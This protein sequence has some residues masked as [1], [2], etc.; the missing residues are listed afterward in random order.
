MAQLNNIILEE[1]NRCKSMS[2]CDA[3]SYLAEQISLFLN[4]DNNI[5]CSILAENIIRN[6]G[7]LNEKELNENPLA[8]LGARLFGK[9]LKNVGTRVAANA[10]TKAFRQVGQN[11][12]KKGGKLIA[13][14][15]K[16]LSHV[17]YVKALQKAGLPQKMTNKMSNK[18]AAQANKYYAQAIT[19]VEKKLAG[20]KVTQNEFDKMVANRYKQIVKNEV[21]ANPNNPIAKEIAQ[22]SGRNA[23]NAANKAA[24]DTEKGASG[25]GGGKS[26][27]PK[28]DTNG[29]KGWWAK[30]KT[31]LKW[32]LSLAALTAAGYTLYSAKEQ[33]DEKMQQA[34]VEHSSA[35]SDIYSKAYGANYQN[36]NE[37]DYRVN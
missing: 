22:N 2:K 19:D 23:K 11:L 21:K 7:T 13:R 14:N 4:E 35:V 10:S 33:D 31:G 25:K 16:H 18:A 20:K 15:T 17:N 6:N 9:G 3:N 5:Y 37:K 30:T 8:G 28:D 27:T 29:G 32:F 34:G 12:I 1:Y 24:K 26:R 36:V